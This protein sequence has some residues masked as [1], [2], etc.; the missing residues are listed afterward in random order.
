MGRWTRQ[1]CND[2]AADGML[3]WADTSPKFIVGKQM[4]ANSVMASAGHRRAGWHGQRA[5]A[6][7]EVLLP[8]KCA[9]WAGCLA[10]W[11]L[12]EVL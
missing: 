6:F 4:R 5:A 2:I 3:T 7:L 11:L 9:R 1:P 8:A 12:C 10:Q